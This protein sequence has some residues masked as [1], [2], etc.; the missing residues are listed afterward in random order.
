MFAGDGARRLECCVDIKLRRYLSA[1][2]LIEA[3]NYPSEIERRDMLIEEKEPFPGAV[4]P[5]FDNFS[6][7]DSDNSM[8]SLS[9]TAILS[10]STPT[11]AMYKLRKQ[12]EILKLLQPI[13][14][15]LDQLESKERK[16]RELQWTYYTLEDVEKHLSQDTDITWTYSSGNMKYESWLSPL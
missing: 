15:N 2:V 5:A 12:C 6:S 9:T 4:L 1:L 10:A 8:S 7:I 14:P 3:R 11:Y 13:I 16:Q